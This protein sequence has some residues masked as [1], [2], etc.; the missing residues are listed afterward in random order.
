MF[1]RSDRF[2][3]FGTRAFWS[4]SFGELD[5]LSLVEF[6]V[7]NSFKTRMVEEQ[8]LV[9]SNVDKSESLVRQS[10]D[11]AFSHL[12]NSSKS[13]SAALPETDLGFI[14]RRQ[15]LYRANWLLQSAAVW[16][17]R[18][19]SVGRIAVDCGQFGC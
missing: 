17:L 9:R 15:V 16:R 12:S 11:R 3:V 14:H 4:A 18:I 7:L 2:D 8:I 6:F 19:K 5:S 1:Q 13:V 10:L